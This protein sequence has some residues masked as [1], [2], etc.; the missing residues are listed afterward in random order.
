M[1]PLNLGVISLS[2]G[3]FGAITFTLCI[4]WDLALPSLS[5]VRLW[6]LLLP[7]FQ[8]ISLASYALGL[9]ESFLYGVYAAVVFVPLYNWLAR[10]L[11]ERPAMGGMSHV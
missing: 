5:M 4:L 10:Q 8:G 7:G 3:L 6:E 9:V 1:K 11:G 2:L